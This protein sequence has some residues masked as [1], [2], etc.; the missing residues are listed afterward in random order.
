M[1]TSEQELE[2]D[3]D[4]HT[5][6]HENMRIGERRKNIQFQHAQTIRHNKSP[7]KACL[8]ID[9]IHEIANKVGE[10]RKENRTP[11]TDKLFDLIM[12]QLFL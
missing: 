10:K 6:E 11:C 9:F 8:N 5:F 7:M 2:K 3:L 4:S 12:S 1:T